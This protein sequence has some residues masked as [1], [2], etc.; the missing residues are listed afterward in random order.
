MRFLLGEISQWRN[1]NQL[2]HSPK[3]A[4][5]KKVSKSYDGGKTWQET[6]FVMIYKRHEQI[7]VKGRS[8]DEE[9]GKLYFEIETI[10]G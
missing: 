6:D 5:L 7:A 10:R 1:L 9:F 2:R 8:L 3:I 4:L